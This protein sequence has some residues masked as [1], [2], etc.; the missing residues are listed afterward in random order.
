[1][2]KYISDTSI[3]F[4]SLIILLFSSLF[5]GSYSP[6]KDDNRPNIIKIRQAEKAIYISS[7]EQKL[8]VLYKG[9]VLK[10]FEIST[11]K[12]GLGFE[13]GSLKTPTGM[14]SISKKIG[15]E[16]PINGIFNYRRYSGK[17][18]IPNHPSYMGKDLITTR[19]LWLSGLEDE[20]KESFQ[21]CIYIHGTPEE[22]YIGQPA[23]HGCIRMRNIDIYA[24]FEFVEKGTPVYIE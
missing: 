16:T 24:V 9:Q 15:A 14:H 11:S 7:S 2:P 4:K 3:A 19:I 13:K 17:L 20:N 18:S 5:L 8:Y 23:S 22:S 21:R 1:M 10:N 6:S 12:Y